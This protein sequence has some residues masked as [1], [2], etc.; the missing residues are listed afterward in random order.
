V[1]IL[2]PEL[3]FRLLGSFLGFA[4]VLDIVCVANNVL[5]W[6]K[7]H[8]VYIALGGLRKGSPNGREAT[9]LSRNADFAAVE[10]ANPLAGSR[11]KDCSFMITSVLDLIS[12][13]LDNLELGEPH[14]L[15]MA[16]FVIV[17]LDDDRA[18]DSG[19]NGGNDGGELHC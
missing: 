4:T 1:E 12:V 8:V 7:G 17:S 18:K 14:V 3:G 16:H 2:I 5:G 9:H 19:S 6:G 10:I 15:N 13:A 11:L